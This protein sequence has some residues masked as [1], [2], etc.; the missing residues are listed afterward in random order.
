M[1]RV[2]DTEVAIVL[3]EEVIAIQGGRSACCQLLLDGC[4]KCAPDGHEHSNVRNTKQ[5]DVSGSVDIQG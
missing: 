5:T 2:N 3:L 1:V 4:H